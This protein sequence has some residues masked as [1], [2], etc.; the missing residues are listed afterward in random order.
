M[1]KNGEKLLY[2]TK[3]LVTVQV[4]AKVGRNDAGKRKQNEEYSSK[5]DEG[6][7]EKGTTK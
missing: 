2:E 5:R 1:K 3:V 7:D 4:G 6:R